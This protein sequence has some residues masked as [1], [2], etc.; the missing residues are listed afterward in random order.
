MI[1]EETRISVL[2]D[3]KNGM[4]IKFV[5]RL[6]GLTLGEVCRIVYGDGSHSGKLDPRW[7]AW[8]AAEWE[9]ATRKLLL[10]ALVASFLAFPVSAEVIY[11]NAENGL[12]IRQKPTEDSASTQVLDFGQKV[13]VIDDDP[14]LGGWYRVEG[15]GYVCGEHTQKTDPFDVMELLGEWRV[16]AYAETGYCCA[17]GSYP[18][19]GY[20]IACNSLPFGT[21][22]FIEDVGFRTVEDRGPTWLGDQWCDLYLGDYNS[23]VQ[24]GDQVKKIWR[25][26]E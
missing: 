12:N 4:P 23:C 11:V 2:T 5:A 20:T 7:V 22:V 19:T 8:F 26:T 1:D 21:E 15:G 6:N 13:V 10:G 3:V 25:V 16:T 17:N 14:D 9:R 24:W 18:Q